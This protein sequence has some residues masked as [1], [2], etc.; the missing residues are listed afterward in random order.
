MREQFEKLEEIAEIIKK[1][2]LFFNDVYGVYGSKS[3]NDFD[4]GFIN[5]AWYAF[6]EQQGKL[7]KANQVLD[8]W[9]NTDK[10]IKYNGNRM[11]DQLLKLKELL[12]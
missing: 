1:G 10:T 12:K 6:Q 4:A 3:N 2:D 11:M 5:G 7:N 9:I 8:E